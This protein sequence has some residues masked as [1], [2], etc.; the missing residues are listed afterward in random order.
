M[1]L[2]KRV[3]AVGKKY[4]IEFANFRLLGHGLDQV[5]VLRAGFRL[6]K[7]PARHRIACGQKEDAD[8]HLPLAFVHGFAPSPCC[9]GWGRAWQLQP[10]SLASLTLLESILSPVK[11]DSSRWLP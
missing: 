2:G 1:H 8:M 10:G 4:E 3:E 6:R 5:V 9:M 7:P 11:F